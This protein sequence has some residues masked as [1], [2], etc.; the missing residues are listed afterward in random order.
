MWECDGCGKC[1]ESIKSILPDFALKNGVCCHLDTE[2]RK[3][4]IYFE[5][6]LVCRVDEFYET[7]LKYSMGK[8][9]YYAQ[10]KIMCEL[11]KEK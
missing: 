8:D 7:N 9:R 3:C 1:C 2:T 5:R 4:R 11:A 10:Q 6:P